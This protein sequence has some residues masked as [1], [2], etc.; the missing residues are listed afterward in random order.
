MPD[1]A[2]LSVFV[3]A[4]VVL[5]VVPGPAVL[6]IVARSIDQGRAAGIVSVLGVTV[7]SAV[8][9]V[10]AALGLSAILVQS[11]TAFSLVKYAG[12]AYL[13]VLGIRKLRERTV[14]VDIAAP[15]RTRHAVIFRQGVVV[16]ILNPKT[17]LFFFA[18][19]PQFVSVSEGSVAVQI[20]FLGALFLMIALISDGA[21]AL[22]AARVGAVLRGN[23]GFVRAQRWFAGSVYIG[24][25]ILTALTANRPASE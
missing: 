12:A 24:L 18:F 25:G 1:L 21:Y 9:I 22:L 4:S 19:L 17:A 16:N 10:A 3:L 7:G 23:L 6:Y 11:A 14:V 8:H 13:I 20:L 5:L 15:R 2:N